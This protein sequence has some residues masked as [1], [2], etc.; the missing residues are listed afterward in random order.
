MGVSARTWDISSSLTSSELKTPHESPEDNPPKRWRSCSVESV[1]A[2]T[3]GDLTPSSLEYDD[4]F[5]D[6]SNSLAFIRKSDPQSGGTYLILDVSQTRALTCHQGQ[7]RLESISLDD[8]HISEQAQWTCTEKNGFKGFRNV[9]E[10]RFLGHDLWWQFGAKALYHSLWES[11]TIARR[12]SGLYWIQ[13]LH[14]WTQWQVS[15]REDGNGICA[16]RDRGTSWE[17]V[18]VL[19]MGE[20]M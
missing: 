11:F 4:D 16:E 14:W 6:Y 5:C 19:S 2:P 7:L 1:D 15:V 10:G 18:K 20:G 17:F 8:K 12:E 3:D 13:M 9:A